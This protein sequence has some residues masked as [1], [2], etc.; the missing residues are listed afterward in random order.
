MRHFYGLVVV[1]LLSGSVAYGGTIYT[2]MPSW[3]PNS[4]IIGSFGYPDT[5]TYG[6]TFIAPSDNILEDFSFQLEGAETLYLRGFV[7]A[8]N[9]PVQGNGNGTG[10][11]LY[12]SPSALVYNGTNAFQTFT[13]NTGGVTLNAGDDYVVGLTVSDPSDYNLNTGSIVWGGV[14]PEPLGDGGGGFVYI[15][16]NSN[17]AELNSGATWTGQYTA[18]AAFT[19]DFTS[20]TPEPASFALIGLG[21]A[22]G[23]LRKRFVAKR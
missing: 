3:V 15:N 1:A 22:A 8:W 5:A 18:D 17:F 12:L 4:D 10:A 14:N 20:A 6:Q 23:L 19:A 16:N 13:V 7:L 2:T 11:F 21:L 9:G